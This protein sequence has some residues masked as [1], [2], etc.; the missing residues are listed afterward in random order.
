M[1]W[2][3]GLIPRAPAPED[4]LRLFR[5]RFLNRTDVVSICAPWGKPCPISP[6]GTLDDLLLGHV[7]GDAVPPTSITYRNRR[8]TGAMRGHFRV[9]TYCPGL[10]DTT[11]WLCIDFDGAGHADPLADPQGTAVSA[12]ATFETAGLAAY[13]ERSGSGQ[14]WHLWCFF[15]PPLAAPKARKLGYVLAPTNAP[16]ADRS[17]VF[18][19]PRL[20]RGIEVFPKQ[21]KLRGRGR[22]GI[23]SPLWLPWWRGAPD[24]A[25]TFYR[26][27]GH[28][29]LEPY[30]P[31]EFVP[32][33]PAA[34]ERVLAQLSPP[35]SAGTTRRADP[36]IDR[37]TEPA[38]PDDAAWAK[39]RRRALAALPIEAVYGDWLTG[40]V[41]GAG[42]LECR[43]PASPSGDQRPSAGVAD[44]TG[45]AE[46]GTF[47]SFISGT[48]LSVFDFLVAHGGATDFRAARQRVA[49]LAATSEPS[50]G[51]GGVR[52][53]PAT[54]SEATR[55]RRK[56]RVVIRPDEHA[57]VDEAIAA[58]GKI[59]GVYQRGP[60]LVH[61]V[62]HD[63]PLAGVIHPA[64]A[65]RIFPFGPA[66]IRDRLTLAA[67]WI[68]VKETS[69]GTLER[70]AH[71]PTW[72]SPEIEA[73]KHWPGVPHLE[74]VVDSPVLRP[75]GTLLERP[76][77]DASTGL[78]FA[79]N[80]RYPPASGTSQLD[81]AAAAAELLDLVVDFPFAS[82]AHR[83]A[84]LAAVLTPLAR[85]A[86]R[87]PS[88]LFV[89]DA[90]VRGAGKTLLVDLVGE[91]VSGREIARTPQAP[92]E[93][94]EIK[95][96]TAIALD[97][98]RMVLIDN[99][100][101]PLGSSA[102]D[103]VLTGTAW[104]ERILG[105]SERVDL[106]LLTVWYASGNNITF[107]GDTARRSLHVRLDSDLDKPELRADF[108]HP[109]LLTWTH[110]HRPRLVMGALTVLRAYCAAGR[111][112]MP[113][114][115]WGSF[116]GWS[117]LVR[118]AIVWAGLADPGTTRA[119][120]DDVDADSTALADLL[121][122]WTELPNRWG[123]TGCTMARALEVLHDDATGRRY[124]R[125]RAALGELCPTPL[126]QLPNARKVG[127][128]LRRFRGRVA[129]GR[130][131][132]T[133]VLEGNQLWFVQHL[134]DA[135]DSVGEPPHTQLAF[136]DGDPSAAETDCG[137][138]PSTRR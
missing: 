136:A 91:I 52:S 80:A 115:T 127:Y 14:G 7:F 126:G 20:A 83:A 18:A 32:V 138:G 76:G 75:D 66:G 72:L 128:V 121:A 77:Y 28:G 85:Y 123:T 130:K 122:G 93:N 104:S 112:A 101:R 134:R 94:E 111:P 2:E 38:A 6:G 50:F 57:V 37:S 129:N 73:R 54:S 100:S 124:P 116:E 11:R 81:A 30:V 36:A 67:E 79:P 5:E 45:E 31:T 49:E 40:R 102:L 110:E 86:F 15:D 17:D 133:R 137:S 48:S 82:D 23:G 114:K 125:L 65:L 27:C 51:T 26:P 47:H 10:D 74:G 117:S 71:P 44:G 68:E 98:T 96:I 63:G 9:G 25:N 107:K 103:A 56:P 99:I 43:D 131:L 58:L 41:A 55:P 3:R 92:D 90:N 35:R 33:A 69:H 61:I 12:L 4:A 70:A 113:V 16:L 8:G 24:G 87:G 19:D 106:P 120:L 88:P 1:E 105:R 135:N 118:N 119:E 29:E 108:K 64:G 109:A 62:K 97:G 46:R 21:D 89:M 22:K 39:W 78:V 13:L 42:W 95:R 60:L 59:D 132:R 53:A 84:W 34:I